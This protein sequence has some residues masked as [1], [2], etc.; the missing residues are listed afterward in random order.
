[1]VARALGVRQETI[2][3]WEQMDRPAIR[4][5]STQP[6]R[7]LVDIAS[8]L[9]DLF[10][11]PK[12]RKEFFSNPQRGLRNRRPIDV[13]AERPPYG[14]HEVWQLLMRIAHGIPS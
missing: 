5:V 14:V 7:E 9:L 1:M 8:L 3:R 2:S 13:L 4:P 10:P 11:D 12:R 6:V